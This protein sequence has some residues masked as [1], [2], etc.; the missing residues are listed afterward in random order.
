[1]DTRNQ[2]AVEDGGQDC[3]CAAADAEISDRLVGEMQ[4]IGL[5]VEERRCK[6][7]EK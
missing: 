1:M 5:F 2:F 7:G 6:S 3:E 4:F